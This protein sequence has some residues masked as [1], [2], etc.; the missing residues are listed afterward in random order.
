VLEH[1]GLEN[2]GPRLAS[3]LLSMSVRIAATWIPKRAA[4]LR[5]GPASRALLSFSPK[6]ASPGAFLLRLKSQ[7]T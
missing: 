6:S 3:S 4:V 1:G 7:T 2:A 5:N